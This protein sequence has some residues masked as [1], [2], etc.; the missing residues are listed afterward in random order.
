MTKGACDRASEV[1]DERETKMVT[2]CKHFGSAKDGYEYKIQAPR[3]LSDYL[4]DRKGAGRGGC[5]DSEPGMV[6]TSF[7]PIFFT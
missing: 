2:Y 4:H 6:S 7:V 1:L 5:Y 3:F